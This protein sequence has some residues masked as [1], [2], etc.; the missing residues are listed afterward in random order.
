MRL[1][2]EEL[3]RLL[4]RRMAT[5]L[6]L[7]AMGDLDRWGELSDPEGLRYFVEGPVRLALSERLG[8]VAAA[9]ATTRMSML[10]RRMPPPFP[11]TH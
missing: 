3:E 9:E 8:P 5:A 7:D 11:P 4:T 2:R 6:L 1:V 10:L